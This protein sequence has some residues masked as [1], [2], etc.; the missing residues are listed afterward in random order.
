MTK[1]EFLRRTKGFTQREFAEKLG[2]HP[3]IISQ[4]EKG[5]RKPYPKFLQKSAEILG[6][7]VDDLIDKEG[8][9]LLADEEFLTVPIRG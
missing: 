7:K 8:N 1:L 4:M 9:L 6:V 2:I 5:F 3:T